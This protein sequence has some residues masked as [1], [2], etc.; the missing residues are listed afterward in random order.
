METP[1]PRWYELRNAVYAREFEHAESL[2]RDSSG[3]VFLMNPLGETVMHFLAV[4]D[5]LE[6]VQWLHARGADLNTK[7]K[8]GTPMLF[9]VAQVASEELFSWLVE[10]GA[11][12]NAT[13]AEGQDILEH[14]EQFDLEEEIRWVRKHVA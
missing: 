7:N 11:D 10:H 5:D 13:D 12:I 8:F 9:E 1:D 2:L 4:E 3:L 14:L 6:G